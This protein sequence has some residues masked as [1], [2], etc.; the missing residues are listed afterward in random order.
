MHRP[1]SMSGHAWAQPSHHW[2]FSGHGTNPAQRSAAPGVISTTCGLQC[3][4]KT[5]SKVS[6]STFG[7]PLLAITTAN[8]DDFSVFIGNGCI[9]C[10]A[11][12]SRMA[13]GEGSSIVPGSSPAGF[14]TCGIG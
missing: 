3:K 6:P 9:R 14:V 11:R 7:L 10:Q 5:D 13:G 8:R 4:R 2:R 1:G 12:S